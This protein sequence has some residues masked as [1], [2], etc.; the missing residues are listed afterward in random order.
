MIVACYVI[1]YD[2][3]YKLDTTLLR[4]DMSTNGSPQDIMS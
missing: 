4:A 1:V 3:N 2:T